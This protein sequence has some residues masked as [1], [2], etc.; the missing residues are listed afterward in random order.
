MQIDML[1]GSLLCT[2]EHE[3]VHYMTETIEHSHNPPTSGSMS[4]KVQRRVGPD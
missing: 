1:Q 4:T 2:L 3:E